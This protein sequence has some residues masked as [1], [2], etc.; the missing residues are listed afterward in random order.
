MLF[1]LGVSLLWKVGALAWPAHGDHAWRDADGLGV[2][3]SFLHEGCNLLEPRVVERGA[4]TG[5]VGMEF[6]LVNWLS[7]LMRKLGGGERDLLARLPV[8][9]SLL[10]LDSGGLLLA[11]RVLKDE[12]A[13]WIAAC[14]LL[15]QPLVIMFS[16]YLMPEIPML[17]LLCWGLVFA[18]DG[19][20]PEPGRQEAWVWPAT[21][22]AATCLALAAVLKPTGVGVAVPL[23]A[24]GAGAWQRGTSADRRALALRGLV[25][26][27]I[28]LAAM[29]LWFGHARALDARY[30]LPLFR[31]RH[32]FWEW[33]RLLF[34]WPFFSVV[35]GRCLHLL[36]LLPT[37]VWMASRWRTLWQVLRRRPLL[38]GWFLAELATVVSFGNHNMHHYY[39][40][41]PLALPACLLVGLT[42]GRV[43]A[44]RPFPAWVIAT[45]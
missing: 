39:Y 37:V 33:T 44:S 9:L 14:V 36:F 11:R 45:T 26:G 15:L 10:P 4:P 8:W 6:P 31:L 41:L 21:L 19:L 35:F 40:A 13:A 24:W 16:R 7:A 12:T 38:W 29:L 28:P 32:D 22:A 43:P 2:A 27:A 20:L 17:A 25:L 23:F 5:I 1:A 30:G 34:T 3:R 18:H 42:L